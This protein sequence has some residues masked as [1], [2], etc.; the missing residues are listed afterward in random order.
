VAKIGL[1][2]YLKD[3]VLQ[4]KEGVYLEIFG[5]ISLSPPPSP[6]GAKNVADPHI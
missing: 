4:P 6:K 2:K 5:H 3:I 1:P